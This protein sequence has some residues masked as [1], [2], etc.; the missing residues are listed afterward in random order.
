MPGKP[1]ASKAIL[2]ALE[3]G[4]SLLTKAAEEGLNAA[5]SDQDSPAPRPVI[6]LAKLR[7][8]ANG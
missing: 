8:A 7:E 5:P 2:A 1:D 4:I 3:Q 6:D